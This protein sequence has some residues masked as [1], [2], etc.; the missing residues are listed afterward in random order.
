MKKETKILFIHNVDSSFVQEDFKILAKFLSYKAFF[1]DVRKSN[2]KILFLIKQVSL[3]VRQFFW[4]CLYIKQ[5][6]AIYCWFSDYHGFL[7]AVFAKIFNKPMITVLGGFDCIKMPHLNYGIF[8]SGWRR[9]LGEFVITK[10][11]MLLPVH[12]SLIHTDPIAKNW[13][14]AH[15]NGLEINMDKFSIPW[16]EVHTGYESDVWS[17]GPLKRDKKVCTVGASGNITKAL[18]KGLDLFVETARYLP[19]FTFTI[20][21]LSENIKNH[22]K[23]RLNAPE[24]IIFLPRQ[25][26]EDLNQIYTDS[27]IYLQLS[28]AEGLPNVLC[29]AMMCG[30]VPVGSAVFGIPDGIGN[31]GYI[32]K[33]PAPLKIAELVKQAHQNEEKLRPKARQHIIDNFSLER[34]EKKLRKSF[35]ELGV[36]D[37]KS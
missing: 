17:E 35:R 32:A 2:S 5:S 10:S 33:D 14:D 7:P 21:G 30:C 15:P 34:R 37:Q 19:D 11:T 22:A 6:K 4:L 12:K 24:N 26:R 23:Q 25:N 27:S 18:R 9:P 31:S 8:C 3:F 36:L 28:K 1:F 16:K 20:V 29:E 13:P